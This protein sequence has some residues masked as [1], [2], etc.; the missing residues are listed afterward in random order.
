L[1]GIRIVQ[2]V[3]V[4]DIEVE[5]E[6]QEVEVQ[7]VEVQEVEVEVEVE[8]IRK[9]NGRERFVEDPRLLQVLARQ[10]VGKDWEVIAIE[11][12]VAKVVLILVV[13]VVAI[14]WTM[15]VALVVV[16]VAVVALLI[17]DIGNPKIA[18][19][20]LKAFEENN[21]CFFELF[22]FVL[23]RLNRSVF[24]KQYSTAVK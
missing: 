24:E 22:V 18:R 20:H 23:Y 3:F 2:V 5:V 9:R 10:Y 19:K 21:Q 13:V 16:T 11:T 4:E 14:I 17:E 7:E 15:I 6:V 8:E 1:L 12:P